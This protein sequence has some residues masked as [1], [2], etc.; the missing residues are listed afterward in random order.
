MDLC[1]V[2]CFGALAH[3]PFLPQFLPWAFA[4]VGKTPLPVPARWLGG[5]GLHH[6]W[7]R[8]LSVQ[9]LLLLAGKWGHNLSGG[10][11]P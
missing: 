3:P 7:V 8:H 4:L 5:P 11:E 1:S 10:A 6:S 2:P 9:H